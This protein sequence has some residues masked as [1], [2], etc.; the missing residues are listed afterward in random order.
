MSAFFFSPFGIQTSSEEHAEKDVI[1]SILPTNDR[2]LTEQIKTKKSKLKT[3]KT[4]H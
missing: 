3:Q 1:P 4:R 2:E